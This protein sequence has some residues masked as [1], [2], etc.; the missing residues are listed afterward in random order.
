V[1]QGAP[2]S[3]AIRDALV[4]QLDPAEAAFVQQISREMTYP[5]RPLPVLPD[6]SGQVIQA[7]TDAS[8]QVAYGRQS[9]PEAVSAFMAAANKAL[10]VS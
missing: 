5:S 4:P 6:A 3:S 10:G 1:D 7:Q 9:I 2:S 8:Q